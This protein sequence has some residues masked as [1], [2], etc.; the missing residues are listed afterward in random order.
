MKKRN[1]KTVRRKRKKYRIHY[2]HLFL[3][4]FIIAFI[5]VSSTLL[6]KQYKKDTAFDK[7]AVWISYIDMDSLKNKD[8]ESFDAAFIEICETVKQYEM[9]TLFV[10][11]RSFQDAIY[12]SAIFPTA[13]YISDNELS[14]DPLEHMIH[15]AH[16]RNL[17]L[18]AWI[19]PYRISHTQEQLEVFMNSVDFP[20]E[21]IL[22]YGNSAILDPSK[23]ESTALIMQGVEELLQYE[24]DGIHMDDYFYPTWAYGDTTMQERKMYVNEM[25]QQVYALVHSYHK[26]FGIS[27]QGNLQN[28]REMGADIDTWLNEDGYIDYLMPQIYWSDHWGMDG[29]IP[30]FTQRIDQWT[31]L[32]RKKDI[33]LYAGLAL[34]LCGMDVAGDR[35]WSTT[36]TNLKQ[37]I[38]MLRD[39]KWSGYSFFSYSSFVLETA[40]QELNHLETCIK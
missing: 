30:M 38:E 36:D 40:K 26:T 1:N 6:F 24:I 8:S 16:E 17:K 35:G 21:N 25:I 10:Q 11:V 3:T 5:V 4:V 19:N 7:K 31:S 37:Q 27:P 18:E 14:Y 20:S 29:S 28:C 32:S 39:K 15:I 23:K 9:D 33:E 22:R 12:P 13:K 2:G 34:Y